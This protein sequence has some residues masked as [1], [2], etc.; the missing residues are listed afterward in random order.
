MKVLSFFFLFLPL[1][2]C[3]SLERK[4]QSLPSQSSETFRLKDRTGEFAVSRSVVYRNG[5]MV[6]KKEVY[7]LNELNKPLEKTVAVADIGSIKTKKGR[8]KSARPSVSQ[9]T[10]WYDKKRFFS[11]LKVNPKKRSLDILMESPEPKWDGSERRAFPKGHVFCFFSQLP[12]CAKI[13]GLLENI[14]KPAVVQVI[15]DNYPYHTEMYEKVSEDAFEKGIWAFD[16]NTKQGYRFGLV[17][18]G[19]LVLYEFDADKNFQNMFWVA[20]GISLTRNK[21]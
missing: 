18:G 1:F 15:W 13:H 19:Q 21:D 7:A 11:Q 10:I 3:S 4:A 9:H 12:E 17:L 16:R 20:Q 6:V 2:G 8:L 14:E 5:K